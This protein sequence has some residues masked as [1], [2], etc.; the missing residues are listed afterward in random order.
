MG[1][2][3]LLSGNIMAQEPQKTQDL[4]EGVKGQLNHARELGCFERA[5]NGAGTPRKSAKLC[6][7]FSLFSRAVNSAEYELPRGGRVREPFSKA[8]TC[9]N[10]LQFSWWRGLSARTTEPLQRASRTEAAAP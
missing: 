2:R 5:L 6:H 4:V 3:K 9:C 1:Q 10:L 8:A 7:F